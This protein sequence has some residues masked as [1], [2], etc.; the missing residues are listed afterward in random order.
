MVVPARDR[1]DAR[2]H[3]VRV[4]G[5]RVDAR[6]VPAP[7]VTV[8]AVALYALVFLIAATC[9]EMGWSAYAVDPLQDR[10][11]A[12]RA[13]LLIG[14]VWAA[15]HII[16][17]LQVRTLPWVAWQCLFTVAARVLIVWIYNGAGRSVP[18][19]IIFHA[20][21]NVCYGV[22]AGAYP[23][24]PVAVLT[25]AATVA[26]AAFDLGP[27]APPMRKMNLYL[28]ARRITAELSHV[29]LANR[30]GD[31]KPPGAGAEITTAIN[32]RRFFRRAP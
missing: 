27:P 3:P 23:P 30:T 14:G 21:I 32:R 22:W 19:A 15:W 18:A 28:P 24:M 16:P 20:M 8:V 26:V 9:E 4:R 7:T 10:W 29:V 17:W 31:H 11:D 6:P 2:D 25:T 1:D 12:I 5:S 13:S